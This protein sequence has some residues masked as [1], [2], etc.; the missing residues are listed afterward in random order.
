MHHSKEVAVPLKIA[1]IQP[2]DN[3]R[4]VF[5]PDELQELAASIK[6]HGLLQP[7][8]V[9]LCTQSGGKKYE[10]VAGERRFRAV[11]L[12]EWTTIPGFVRTLS[13]EQAA[14]LM[15]AENV[16]RADLDA[17]DEAHAYA[18]RIEQFGWS[19][20]EC[21]ERSKKNA[22]HVAARLSLLDLLPEVQQMIRT[23]QIAVVFGET[24]SPL[25]SNRQRIA[26]EYLV[27]TEKP[28]LREFKALVGRL[29]AEQAQE[30]LFDIQFAEQYVNDAVEKHNTERAAMLKR[31]FPID[32]QLP[33]MERVGSI[34][35]TFEAYIKQL[36]G[37]DNPYH[38]QIA[39]VVGTIYDSLLR[40]GMAFP[41]GTSP[42][43]KNAKP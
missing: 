19:V 38:R 39:P 28:L 29:L 6:E 2:G 27:Q 5:N 15:L 43:R 21:A 31:K 11:Q 9:R 33:Q 17:L 22:R 24:M 41:P 37:S 13:D 26:L 20:A 12:L 32:P 4:T 8:T 42:K 7:I 1:D 30:T 18:K 16:Q 34:G 10:I 40:G 3:D 23:K 14:S 35:A 36:L 25:D